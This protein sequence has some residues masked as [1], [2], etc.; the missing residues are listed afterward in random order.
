MSERL[1]HFD[2]CEDELLLRLFVEVYVFDGDGALIGNV[3]RDVHRPRR[4]AQVTHVNTSHL[5]D[6]QFCLITF[7]KNST[8][9]TILTP[10]LNQT[11]TAIENTLFMPLRVSTSYPAP[12]CLHPLPRP[13][14]LHSLPPPHTTTLPAPAPALCVRPLPRSELFLLMVNCLRV[15]R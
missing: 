14:Q 11:L 13:L 3:S 1:H 8:L 15:E 9:K 10:K 2:F 7:T 6:T 4:P 12:T 5:H